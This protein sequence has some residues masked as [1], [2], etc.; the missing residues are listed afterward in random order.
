MR[1]PAGREF[2]HQKPQHA[3]W[4]TTFPGMNRRLHRR[5]DIPTLT[6]HPG[7]H[8][9]DSLLTELDQPCP[10]DVVHDQQFS[11][12]FGS[13]LPGTPHGGGFMG[14]PPR[15]F[16]VPRRHPMKRASYRS[17]HQ[18]QQNQPCPKQHLHETGAKENRGT[19]GN[20]A[21]KRTSPKNSFILHR[22]LQP[23]SNSP[24]RIA[25]IAAAKSHLARGSKN[26]SMNGWV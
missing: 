24:A 11:R 3:C 17:R 9:R 7:H 4:W 20:R 10:V 2:I 22:S 14:R 19:K 15:S 23:P 13:T 16:Q 18:A 5:S 21:C 8:Q 1:R 26:N 12:Q 6:I 25:L